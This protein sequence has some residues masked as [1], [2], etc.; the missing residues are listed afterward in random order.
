MHFQ[1][2]LKWIP[3]HN[4]HLAQEQGKRSEEQN[5]DSRNCWGQLTPTIHLLTAT[6]TKKMT[7]LE[8]MGENECAHL[9]LLAKGWSKGAPLISGAE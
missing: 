1:Q 7:K 9:R 6:H 8:F 5:S 2:Q 4:L 3:I